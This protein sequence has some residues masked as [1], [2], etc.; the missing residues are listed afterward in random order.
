MHCWCR[1]QNIIYC[2]LVLYSLSNQ[3]HTSLPEMKIMSFCVYT[4]I[5]MFALVYTKSTAIPT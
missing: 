5:P 4:L 1:I 3:T 2:I